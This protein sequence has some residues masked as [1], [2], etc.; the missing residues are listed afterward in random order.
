MN[1]Q[2]NIHSPSSSFFG[3]V[4]TENLY[5]AVSNDA[6]KHRKTIQLS[7]EARQ[8]LTPQAEQNQQEAIERL[9]E[10]KQELMDAKSRFRERAL[11]AGQSLDD[12]QY[13]LEHFDEQ[14]ENVNEWIMAIQQAEMEKRKREKEE[15]MEER[16]QRATDDDVLKYTQL[17][18]QFEHTRS[19]ERVK[20]LVQQDLKYAKQAVER[21]EARGGLIDDPLAK[22]GAT[23]A[24]K[25]KVVDLTKRLDQL[26]TASERSIGTAYKGL[27]ALQESQTEEQDQTIDKTEREKQN[28]RTQPVDHVE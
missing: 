19:I 25:E 4:K 2:W 21:D 8:R 24:Q 13:K 16:T 10:R 23:D 18:R 20:S 1:I 14:I 15:E 9:M 17:L 28:E 22:V 5:A 27:I 7:S 12:I 6:D 11:E 26:T 3:Y